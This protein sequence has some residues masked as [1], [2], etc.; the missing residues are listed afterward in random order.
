MS[1]ASAYLGTYS[2]HALGFI[3][4]NVK[5]MIILPNGS[6]GIG[7][8]GAAD[9]LQVGGDIRVG[10][11]STGCVK[12]ADGTV[13]AGV[14]SSD[15]RF[16]HSIVPFGA[17]LDRVA[18]LRPVHFKWRQAEYPEKHFGDGVSFGL[19]AQDVA[20]VLPELV[21]EDENGFKAIRYNKLPLLAIQAIGELKAENDD[22]REELR[23]LRELVDGLQQLFHAEEARTH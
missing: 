23:Q 20:Q 10:S 17:M 11:G 22:L 18:A 6:V 21:T 1:A 3:T 12:D 5:R 2:N 16:K 15:L 4:N 7:T 9:L 19:V 14:C 8:L 13:I